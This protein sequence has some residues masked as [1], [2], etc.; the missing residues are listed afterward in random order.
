M[1]FYHRDRTAP[2]DGTVKL[3]DADA[4][5]GNRRVGQSCRADSDPANAD[6]TTKIVVALHCSWGQL[7]VMPF[8]VR[9]M[10]A[11]DPILGACSG[12]THHP[13]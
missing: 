8:S 12:G 2:S 10:P 9:T 11:A 1:I 5:H 6:I 7:L 3:A 4:H 13:G